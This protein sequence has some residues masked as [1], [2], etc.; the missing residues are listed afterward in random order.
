MADVQAIHEPQF[1]RLMACVEETRRVRGCRGLVITGETGSGKSHLLA[2][3]R[4]WG[5]NER[6][7]GCLHIQR[8]HEEAAL[9]PW[10]ITKAVI[11]QLTEP[12]GCDAPA[13]WHSEITP[14]W[15]LPQARVVRS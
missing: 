4:R 15:N 9:A 10:Q 3:L 5:N 14:S 12:E 7:A 11:E 8:L 13:T 1:G 6:C 2:R